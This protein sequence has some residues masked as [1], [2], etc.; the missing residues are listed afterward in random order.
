MCVCVHIKSV[1]LLEWVGSYALVRMGHS[2]SIASCVSY[3]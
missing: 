3:K 2:K 1:T